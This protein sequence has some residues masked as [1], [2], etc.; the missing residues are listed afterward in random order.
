MLL[1]FQKINE[2]SLQRLQAYISSIRTSSSIA[3]ISLKFYMRDKN[4]DNTIFTVPTGKFEK[5]YLLTSKVK[6]RFHNTVSIV[7]C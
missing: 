7:N 2:T 3:P 5:K 4:N 6:R 1:L